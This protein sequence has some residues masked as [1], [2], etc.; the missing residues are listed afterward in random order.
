MGRRLDGLYAQLPTLECKGLCAHSCIPIDVS[1]GER[2]RIRREYDVEIPEP[3]EL[4]AQGC[5][6]CVALKD[7]RCSVYEA[8]PMICRLWGID[9]TMRCPHGCVPEGG[10]LPIL[11]SHGFTLK[12]YLIA[13]WPSKMKA[14][15]PGEVSAHL[16]SEKTRA[17]LAEARDRALA[18]AGERE[19]KRRFNPVRR[20]RR[21][22]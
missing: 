15:T 13:G 5:K 21:T 9:E 17:F 4:F 3:D 16:R 20:R 19:R 7:G 1:P 22:P 8:R 12:T 18:N 2:V 10:W 11:Q 14:M 6:T